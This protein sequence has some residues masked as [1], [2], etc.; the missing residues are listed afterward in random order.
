M[1]TVVLMRQKLLSYHLVSS[2]SVL[3]PLGDSWEL[4]TLQIQMMFTKSYICYKNT[5]VLL[6]CWTYTNIS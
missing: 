3:L 6:F 4:A 5:E 2:L 1:S